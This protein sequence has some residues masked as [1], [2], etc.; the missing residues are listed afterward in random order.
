MIFSNNMLYVMYS[1]I[2]AM[3][4]CSDIYVLAR[5]LQ[6]L[7]HGHVSGEIPSSHSISNV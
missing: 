6:A 7:V 1:Y 3:R 4:D 5:G 2:M